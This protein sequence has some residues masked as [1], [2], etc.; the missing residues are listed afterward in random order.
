MVG[1]VLYAEPVNAWQIAA[2]QYLQFV[3]SSHEFMMWMP[4]INIDNVDWKD[5]SFV[6]NDYQPVPDIRLLSIDEWEY[7]LRGRNNGLYL[8]GLGKIDSYR[9]SSG[10]IVLPD[11][12]QLP[13]G[14][15]F[16]AAATKSEPNFTD[17]QYTI[18]EWKKM[19]EAGALFLPCYGYTDENGILTDDVSGYYLSSD[20][21]DHKVNY[22]NFGVALGKGYASTSEKAPTTYNMCIRPVQDETVEGFDNIQTNSSAISVNKQ[23]IDGQLYILRDGVYYNALGAK[24]K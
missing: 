10:L 6:N 19:E 5:A 23:I 21:A 22:L 16:V 17:N 1:N 11:D 18:A 14:C 4:H 20:V 7:L 13:E 2:V 8:Y 3:S 12:W 9:K 15:S 24:I